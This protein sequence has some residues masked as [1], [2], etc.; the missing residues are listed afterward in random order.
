M[1]LKQ[2]ITLMSIIYFYKLNQL[3]SILLETTQYPDI[4]KNCNMMEEHILL[5]HCYD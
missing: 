1:F 5:S 3:N 4:A 2:Q